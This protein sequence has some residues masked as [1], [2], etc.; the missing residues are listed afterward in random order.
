MNNILHLK[1]SLNKRSHPGGFGSPTL[2]KG[3]FVT[4]THLSKIC[5]ELQQI[6]AYWQ[7][8]DTIKGALVSVH[9]SCIVA[10][11]NRIRGLLCI[12]DENTSNSIR[13]SKFSIDEPIKHIFTHYVKLDVLHESIRRL[14]ICINIAENEFS[15]KITYK[16]I[17]LLNN[18]TQQYK[19]EK[20]SRSRFT[21]VIVDSYY[22]ARFDIDRDVE[23]INDQAIIS[24][25]RTDIKTTDLLRNLG[26][27][28]IDAKV[29]DDVTVRLTPDELD[30]LKDN[31]PYLI[32]MQVKDLTKITQADIDEAD[33]RMIQI[34]APKQ[35]PFIGVIDTLFYEDVYF[36]DWVTYIRMVDENIETDIRDCD[37]GTAV[38]SLIVDGPTINPKLD[39][40][41]GRFRVKHF[42]VATKGSFS[43]FSIIR[44]IRRIVAEN[45][46]IKVWNLSLGSILEINKNFISP[47]AALLDKIQCDYDVIFVVAGTNKSTNTSEDMYIGYP[48][49]SLN[50]I[51][52]NSVDFNNK[53]VSYH[54]VGP[55]L[56]FFHKPD[57]SYYGGDDNEKIRVCRPYGQGYVAGTSFAAP[58]VSRK[59]AFLIH[60]M[61]IPR[62]VAKALIID[63]A[64]SWNRKDDKSHAIGYGVV[65]IRIEEILQ[66][67]SDE[68]RFILTGTADEYET[69]TYNIPV[70][71]YSDKHPFFARAT[72][73]YFPGS[74][75]D[76]GVDYTNTEMDIHFGRVKGGESRSI[77][78]S[79]NDNR[80]GNE[81]F[82]YITEANARRLYRKWDN[83]KHICES[84]NKRARPKI[85]YG[86]GMWGL[87][88]KI[89]DRL[90]TKSGRGL[91][92]GVV[93]TLKEMQGENRIDDFIKQCM[94]RGW[95][96]NQID[97]ENQFDIYNKA[98]E[99]IIFE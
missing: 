36:K 35:E 21:K 38:S 45:R 24:I 34:P 79:I 53:P 91:R 10:K 16:D 39:D 29:I 99:D 14:Q 5:S 84:I 55:V 32:S 68:I 71:V 93:V 23:N 52:V 59:L 81:G 12:G 15:G 98:E 70:P 57:V 11:S 20:L 30:I 88:I 80:Q 3:A 48:A 58:W 50:S 85:S 46:D 87:S 75:R 18:K 25:Y 69:Y 27:D 60:N 28:M 4:S 22:I 40:G 89:K 94:F 51:V 26:I 64:A 31:A 49:D 78:K 83:I 95:I 74:S 96:V 82:N 67:P 63:A 33:P 8:D 37:H 77:I 41:C 9:Y 1:G 92:F 44:D 42:G 73:C 65:P 19:N 47:E 13:G 72:L 90:D 61:G 54:R 7:N 6:L 86:V 2:P 56:S 76:Q 66:T 43:S 17:E 62:E 97:V